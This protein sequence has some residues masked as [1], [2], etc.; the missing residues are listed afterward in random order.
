MSVSYPAGHPLSR[1]SSAGVLIG[2]GGSLVGL[3]AGALVNQMPIVLA[4][5][6]IA[7]LIVCCFLFQFEYSIL[8]LFIV[9]S[10]LDLFSAQQ[11]PAA[12]ALG[13]D[14]FTIAYICYL[15]IARKQIQLDLFW[16]FY[17]FWLLLQGLWIV[18]IPLGAFDLGLAS[19]SSG[20][21]EWIRMGSWVLAY[22]LILQLRGKIPPETIVQSLFFA[23]IVP[24]T[25]AAMQLLLPPSV[26]PDPLVFE[27]GGAFEANSRISGS[28]GH[29]NTFGT[30]LLFF[31][32]LAYWQVKR[33]R[34]PLRWLCLLGALVFFLVSTKALGSLAMFAAFAVV[35]VIPRLSLPKLLGSLLLVAAIIALFG[36]TEFGRERLGSI[37]ATP[38]LNP[39]I[40]W[41]R[42]VLMSWFD[43]NSFNWRI[44]QWTLLIDAWKQAPWLG[45]GIYTSSD[46]TILYNYAHNDYVR[47]LA[48]GGVVGLFLFVLLLF[49]QLIRL[50]RIYVTS[51]YQPSRQTLS[52]VMLSF[53]VAIMVGMATENVWTHTTL[54]FYWWVVF[55]VLGW[56]W[57]TDTQ[58]YS[59]SR[60][61]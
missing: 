27:G 14:A 31:M 39:N 54:F 40:D 23:L 22:L 20:L 50:I 30:F 47:A 61:T 45:H 11:L 35:M 3:F 2:L 44:S 59:V 13:L 29:A 46:L 43:H 34:Q 15:S 41:S 24:L 37:A 28:L 7:I 18:L 8:G 42:A 19:V 53:L 16:C 58:A 4:A 1:L 60:L 51:A 10:S 25:T 17:L 49:A 9:R 26:L 38:L 57:E 6:F 21:R 48:E 55:A 52:A 12:F 5:A 36:S 33:Q 32:G 56:E